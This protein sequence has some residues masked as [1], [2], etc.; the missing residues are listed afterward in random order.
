M[1]E[2]SFSLEN[3]MAWPTNDQVVVLEATSPLYL[4]RGV[5]LEH[6]GSVVRKYLLPTN[7]DNIDV[8]S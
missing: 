3:L 6:V 1:L 5:V 4:P 8:L 2:G 7:S